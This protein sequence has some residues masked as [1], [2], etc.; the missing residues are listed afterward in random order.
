MVTNVTQDVHVRPLL[1]DS[2]LVSDAKQRQLFFLFFFCLETALLQTG[3]FSMSHISLCHVTCKTE[4]QAGTN[5]NHLLMATFL[6]LVLNQG[7]AR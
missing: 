3:C 7:L 5:N 4:T 2:C 1:K 6:L